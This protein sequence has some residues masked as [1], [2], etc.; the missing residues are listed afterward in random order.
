MPQLRTPSARPARNRR[1]ALLALVFGVFLVLIGVTATALV[2]ITAM[3]LSSATLNAVVSRDR[4]LVELFVNGNI[5]AADIDANGPTRSSA[6]ALEAKLATLTAQ[7]DI[8]RIDLRSIDG[9]VLASS[10]TGMRGSSPEPSD[11]MVAAID[12][13]PSVQLLDVAEATDAADSPLGSEQVVQEYLPLLSDDGEPLAVVAVWRDAVP[14]LAAVDAARRDIVIV[15]LAAAVLLGLV[16]LGV[17]WAAQKRILRQQADLVE[18]ERRDP[19]TNLLNHGA[20]VTMLAGEVESARAKGRRFGLALVDVDNFRLFNDTHGHDAADQVLLRVA[21]WL[22]R[23]EGEDKAIARYGPDEFLLVLPGAGQIEMEA[24]VSRIRAGLSGES[25]QFG[26]SEQLP[27]TVSAGIS[28]YPLHADSVT[29]LLTALTVAVGEAKASGGDAVCVARLGDERQKEVSGSF[30][31][32][33]GLVIAVDSKDRY[34]KRHSEDVARYAVFL[35]GQL[36]LDDDLRRTIHLSGL[37]HD[38]GKIGIPD[39]LLRKPS[40]L[41]AEEFDVFKQHVALG[42]AIVRDIPNVDLV[43]AGIRHHHERWDGKGYLEGLEGGDIPIIAR[44]LAVADAFSAMTT[45]RPYRKA[46]DVEEALKRLGD[47][48][49][50]QLEEDLV[51]AFITGMETAPDAPMP[52]ERPHG[53][54]RPAEWVA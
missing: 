18:A 37:L 42:D 25:V 15:T 22:Q 49:G 44:V 48:A 14:L 11:S 33:Q 8:L 12:G 21:A 47:A 35:A 17:F 20:I 34:T 9:E 38:V 32:L 1:P 7:D 30:D 53:I 51:I 36:G 26:E 16:L 43:R 27:V 23:E 13:T 10:T 50:R 39:H 31:V 41:T 46:L 2:A 4:S 40:K 6:E 45:T 19:L 54:W 3:H 28:L 5:T 24:A 29:E 52:A